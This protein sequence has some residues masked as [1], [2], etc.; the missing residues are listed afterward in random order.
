MFS[1][2]DIVVNLLKELRRTVTTV[3]SCTG[4]LVSA[5]LVNVPGVS[6][7]FREG[8]ITYSDIAKCNIIGVS[9]DTIRKFGVVSAQVAEEMAKKGALKA[10]ADCAVSTTGVAGPDG[11]DEINPVGTVYIACKVSDKCEVKRF[12]FDGD[13]Q[14]IRNCAASMAINMLRNGLESE[15]TYIGL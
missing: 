3:E 15:K 9:A 7:V 14:N 1:D 8:Y 13:R 11:G 4:G 2:E 12:K 10:C 6:D 5:R